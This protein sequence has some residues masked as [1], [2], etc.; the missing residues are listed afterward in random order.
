MD[1]ESWWG[2]GGH[3][4][5]T[6]PHSA[7]TLSRLPLTLPIPLP[8]FSPPSNSFKRVSAPSSDGAVSRT[9]GPATSL[10][11]RP[12][13]SSTLLT[14]HSN[15]SITRIINGEQT[16]FRT[17]VHQHP[18]RYISSSS[19]IVLSVSQ[20]KAVVWR[21]DGE[22][23]KVSRSMPGDFRC[24]RTLSSPNSTEVGLLFS[25]SSIA[26]YDAD[27]FAMTRQY[28]LPA[29]EGD[30]ALSS[31]DVSPD[32]KF[33]VAAGNNA[34]LYL[35]DLSSDVLMYIAEM[36]PS[37]SAVVQ[38]EYAKSY[39]SGV[40]LLY[41]LGDDGRILAL[42]F[43]PSGCKVVFEIFSPSEALVHF[44]LDRP[45]KYLAASTSTGSLRLY[46]LAVSK[47]TAV[48]VEDARRRMGMPADQ[49]VMS[50]HT[51]S[52]FL[53][54]NSSNFPP[55]PPAA[56]WSSHA[57]PGSHAKE[58]VGEVKSDLI[59]NVFGAANKNSKAE[60][61]KKKNEKAGRDAL[62]RA[63]MDYDSTIPQTAKNSGRWEPLYRLAR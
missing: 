40:P 54:N 34:M 61:T 60:S 63:T 55:R 57:D 4:I 24:G 22:K 18:V 5:G 27:C 51:R 56:V 10:T 43:N 29:V 59:E 23:L 12:P 11:Y 41:V 45:S 50:L 49:I 46:D 36:P 30:A 21:D 16:E 9:L 3:C 33:L 20:D 42:A 53:S 28:T 26:C 6:H 14:G 7:L 31:F 62:M 15:G 13:S 52:P 38:L 32:G 25:D 17:S 19:S 35:W 58:L 44:S 48:A 47:S 2:E 39:S 37:A 1:G 8:Q